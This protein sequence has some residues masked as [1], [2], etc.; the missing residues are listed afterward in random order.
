MTCHY[1]FDNTQEDAAILTYHLFL[2]LYKLGVG[3]KRVDHNQKWSGDVT[4]I[5]E[6]KDRALR[7]R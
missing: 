6:Y 4:L 1:H 5:L 7:L 2:L 3:V